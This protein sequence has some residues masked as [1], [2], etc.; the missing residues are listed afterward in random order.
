[1]NR[2]AP[3]PFVMTSTGGLGGGGTLVTEHGEK[4]I[5]TFWK[6]QNALKRFL[7]KEGIKYGYTLE[8]GESGES[9]Q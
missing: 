9:G 6:S 7:E 4:A 1:M 2:Q 5:K 8:N 3:E